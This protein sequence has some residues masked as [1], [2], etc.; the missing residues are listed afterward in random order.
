MFYVKQTD[1]LLGSEA[2]NPKRP[3]TSVPVLTGSDARERRH[4]LL[5][6]AESERITVPPTAPSVASAECMGF[7]QPARRVIWVPAAARLPMAK[8]LAH[9][10]AHHFGCQDA[11]NPNSESMTEAVAFVVLQAFGLG[12]AARSVPSV[13][14]REAKQTG[15]YKRSSLGMQ[16]TVKTVIERTIQLSIEAI[17][18][19]HAIG[20]ARPPRRSRHL[21]FAIGRTAS[22]A[23]PAVA[24]PSDP[25][26]LRCVPSVRPKAQRS[27]GLHAAQQALREPARNM[28]AEPSVDCADRLLPSAHWC[29]RSGPGGRGCLREEAEPDLLLR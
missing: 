26:N 10:P 4:R 28:H 6:V 24:R 5:H 22:C 17:A 9:E 14:G 11:S 20:T 1:A 27:H 15:G 25:S 16:R 3:D 18:A 12:S 23:A 7:Y 29:V 19:S 13:T 2:A 21:A 8:T